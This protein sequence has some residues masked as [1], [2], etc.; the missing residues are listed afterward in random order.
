MAQSSFEFARPVSGSVI[1]R[2]DHR[3]TTAARA[4]PEPRLDSI[5]IGENVKRIRGSG[6]SL[7]SGLDVG[8]SGVCFSVS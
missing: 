8:G 3:K 4:K 1:S 2:K 6:D 7:N 5:W